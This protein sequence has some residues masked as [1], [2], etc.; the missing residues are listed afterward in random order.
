VFDFED[1]ESHEW[2]LEGEVW[3]D[4]KKLEIV[5]RRVKKVII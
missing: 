4:E 5:I 2:N 3:S 1:V